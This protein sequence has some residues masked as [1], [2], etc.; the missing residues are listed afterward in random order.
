MWLD[1]VLEATDDFTPAERNDVLGETAM[2]VYG[3]AH[4]TKGEQSA[5][6]QS[7]T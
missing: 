3:L 5:C 2:R 1:T 6:S 7:S 4:P